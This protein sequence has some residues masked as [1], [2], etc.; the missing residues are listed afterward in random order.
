L[1]FDVGSGLGDLEHVLFR[2]QRALEAGCLLDR[3]GIDPGGVCA[4]SDR[5]AEKV[6]PKAPSTAA[7]N[8]TVLRITT[9]IAQATQ[10]G[11]TPSG[12]P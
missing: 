2:A 10:L 8:A 3:G 4:T 11:G 1:D 12:S 9:S 5:A 6:S 7:A